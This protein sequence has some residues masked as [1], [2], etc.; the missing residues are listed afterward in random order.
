MENLRIKQ[1][2]LG[3]KTSKPTHPTCRNLNTPE[4]P[5]PRTRH[6]SPTWNRLSLRGT[7]IF[8]KKTLSRASEAN[9]ERKA[10]IRLRKEGS[11]RE[12]EDAKQNKKREG[13]QLGPRGLYKKCQQPGACRFTDLSDSEWLWNTTGQ[14]KWSH[15]DVN[16]ILGGERQLTVLLKWRQPQ[17][18]GRDWEMDSSQSTANKHNVVVD[19]TQTQSLTRETTEPERNA[20]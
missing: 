14:A 15:H 8:Q 18:H 17:F 12:G 19:Y 11:I 2:S 7:V 3:R 5:A 6:T 4:I 13:C 16:L 1:R 9:A 10:T 20:F